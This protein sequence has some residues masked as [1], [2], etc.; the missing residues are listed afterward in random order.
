MTSQK[1]LSIAHSASSSATL[2]EAPTFELGALRY[3]S[4]T[5]P[6]ARLKPHPRNARTHSQRQTNKLKLSMTQIGFGSPVVVDENMTI[7]AGHARVKVAKELSMGLVPVY[8]IFGLTETR[9][10]AYLL[11][12]NRVAEDAGWDRSILAS[13]FPELTPLLEEE[14]LDLT[15]TGFDMAEIDRINDDLSDEEPEEQVDLTLLDEA[16]VCRMGDQLILGD[17][18]VVV[19]DALDRASFGWLMRGQR[20]AA[21]FLDAPYNI[22]AQLIGGR[23]QAQHGDFAMGS[24]EMSDQA[25]TEFLTITHRNVAACC[26]DGAIVYSCMDWR[27]I[28][29]LIA[30]GG[31]AFERL[32]N[33]VVW[34][35][36]NAG[37][38]SFYRSQHELIAVF[39]VGQRQHFNNVQQGRFGRNRSNVWT[40]P[41]ANTFRRGR[42]ED[43]ADHPTVKNT[44]MVADAL[45]DCTR[46]GDVV[47][48]CFGGSGTTLMAAEKVGRRAR[49]IEISPQY[50]DVI[51]RRWQSITK[52][53]AVHRETG[54]TF[55]ELRRAR[56][57]DVPQRTRVRSVPSH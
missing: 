24:G 51:V 32:L 10:R 29:K 45:K 55:E 14:D 43:L 53:D 56:T 49:L 5:Y 3:R 30:A 35:K 36:T 17:H 38:G 16:T 12:D 26:A 6:A 2:E 31:R 47:L 48:D 1:K 50:A 37:Q 40:Y 18:R 22:K 23:G 44:E 27:Q 39:Q 46:L 25:F 19:A 9:K 11:A 7:L 20:A 13:E 15:V 52:G 28:E 57:A 33:I 34:V 4:G 54:L 42:L 21:S 41:G 8:Q